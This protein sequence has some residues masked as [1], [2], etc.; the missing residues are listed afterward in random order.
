MEK[1]ILFVL[2]LTFNLRHE[3]MKMLYAILG[4]LI[5]L[6]GYLRLCCFPPCTP[7]A[8]SHDFIIHASNEGLTTS[9]NLSPI[10]GKRREEPRSPAMR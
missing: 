10:G 4:S 8:P 9:D 1:L 6:A 2:S 3:I 5:T 7:R